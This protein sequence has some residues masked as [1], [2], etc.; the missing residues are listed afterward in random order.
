M[1]SQ[2]QRYALEMAFLTQDQKN[3]LLVKKAKT[4]GS[5]Q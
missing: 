3:A 5:G 2:A 1:I 4:A